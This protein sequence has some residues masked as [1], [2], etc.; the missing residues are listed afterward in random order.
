MSDRL[1][2]I[3]C[4]FATWGLIIFYNTE[5]RL[6]EVVV[7]TCAILLIAIIGWVKWRILFPPTKKGQKND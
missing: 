2:L 5:S 6:V 4:F 1:L 3:T 7:G